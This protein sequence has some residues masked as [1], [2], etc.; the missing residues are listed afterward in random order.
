MN[1]DWNKERQKII[2]LGDSS[3]KKSYYP[4]LQEKIS[5]LE[6]NQHNLQT[7]IKSLNVAVIVHTEVGKIL[8]HNPKA[9][10]MLGIKE[11]NSDSTL[12]AFGVSVPAQDLLIKNW[13][14][15]TSGTTVTFEWTL[16]NLD[17]QVFVFEA[18]VS[19]II[20]DYKTELISVLTN[21]TYQKEYEHELIAAK[22]EALESR[23]K[24]KTL[25]E[26]A[27]DGIVIGNK[28]GQV[29][30][31][32]ESFCS[33]SGYS[34]EE[35]LNSSYT[36]YF[37]TE[38]IEKNPFR[39][40]SAV[41]GKTIVKERKLKHKQ[42]HEIVLQMT[43]RALSDGRLQVICRDI[44]E[45]K[46]TQGK[47]EE[48][49]ERLDS[50]LR[51][52]NEGIWDWD[53]ANNKM[54]FDSR[55]YSMAGYEPN[56][57]E[58]SIT[59]W[60]KRIHKNDLA[61]SQHNLQMHIHG[62]TDFY[63]TEFQFMRK[64]KKWMWI[65]S[66][67]KAIER[68]INGTALRI[69]GTHTDITDRKIV[70]IELTKYKDKLEELVIE[71]TK[72]IKQLNE[73][74]LNSNNE[75][76]K[77]NEELTIQK[78]NL[79][80]LLEELRSTQEQLIQSEKLA[81]I[82]ILTAGIAHEINNPINFI[83]SG[84]IGLEVE[85]DNLLSVMFYLNKKCTA[86]Q[87]GE[88]KSLFAEMKEKFE[89]DTTIENIPK[90]ISSIKTGV[91][92]TT[93]IVK[94]L[95]TFSR[96]DTENK[97][98]ADINELIESSLTLLYNRYKHKITIEKHYGNLNKTMCFPGKLSQVFLNIIMNSVQAIEE[99]GVITIVTK[100]IKKNQMITVQIADTG[101]GIPQEKLSKIFDPFYTTKQVG[102]GTGLGLPIVLGIIKDHGGNIVIES[103][104]G[105][106]TTCNI[107]LPV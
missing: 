68:D 53:L 37:S 78:A 24:Y 96:L 6:S 80:N 95:R 22:L 63:D 54:I 59:E 105:K 47:L 92:R 29:I 32:N 34:K 21:I 66:R 12:L 97:V 90:L 72:K 2:G 50:A 76:R 70:E 10:E 98:E 28:R 14:R 35:L 17:D 102:L 48:S 11:K 8:A 103:E 69:I 73:S 45:I 77:L 60:K 5:A 101:S 52:V 84:V 27:G 43:T 9:G 87:G 58:S 33:L 71:R 19:P 18:T 74:L 42:G 20:W 93:N 51:A 44:T 40:E 23:E 85:I 89:V 61:L 82:G 64:N 7:I 46:Q 30:D 16:L 94:G 31:V 39:F 99:E 1:K 26:Q 41:L 107:N 81:S 57:F 104:L 88:A 38:E 13:K 36:K 4:E 67:G 56:E 83:S 15:A 62:K 65:R 25:F 75:L 55:F 49:E 91:D 79:E 86:V 3:M 100:Y 106:G